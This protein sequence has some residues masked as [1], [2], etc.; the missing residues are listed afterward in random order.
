MS[1]DEPIP[2]FILDDI[3]RIEQITEKE[4]QT[5][6][7]GLYWNKFISIFLCKNC[8][9]LIRKAAIPPGQTRC[10]EKIKESFKKN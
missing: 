5:C 7:L 10:V 1:K 9:F 4:S 6:G 3:D 2:P 8:K